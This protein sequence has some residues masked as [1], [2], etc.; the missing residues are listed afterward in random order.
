M[1]VM[2]L[3][4]FVLIV[5]GTVTRFLIEAC[6]ALP[7]DGRP[8]PLP[9]IFHSSQTNSVPSTASA[10]TV[11]TII[12]NAEY[13]VEADAEKSTN[14]V[15]WST[16]K[17]LEIILPEQD[18]ASGSDGFSDGKVS[19]YLT[20]T[21]T[22]SGVSPPALGLDVPKWTIPLPPPC[23]FYR[24]NNLHCWRS[25]YYTVTVSEGPLP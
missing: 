14:L 22:S 9:P 16:L 15:D 4:G 24:L 23:A 6:N 10:G 18:G 7:I 20:V 8:L 11:L 13:L 25:E 17:H 2:L 3:V 1:N 19:G 5:A 21:V 12:T